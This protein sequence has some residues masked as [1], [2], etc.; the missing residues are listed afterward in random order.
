M[1]SRC[2]VK[3]LTGDEKPLVTVV[4]IVV[5]I[6]S[7]EMIGSLEDD[8]PSSAMDGSI[9]IMDTI[10]HRDDEIPS[11][12]WHTRRH[13]TH[14]TQPHNTQHT[15]HNTQHT[16]QQSIYSRFIS[17]YHLSSPSWSPLPYYCTCKI[18]QIKEISKFPRSEGNLGGV[19]LGSSE[20][21][22]PKGVWGGRRK[23]ENY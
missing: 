22:D 4:E 9:E 3:T 18:S 7:T 21:V 2:L 11:K 15:T 19:P 16:T 6:V 20:G 17:N 1:W 5:E 23:I 14:N 10:I 8:K 13:T 12:N